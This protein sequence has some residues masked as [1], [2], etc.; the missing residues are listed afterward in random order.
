[1][2]KKYK[3]NCVCNDKSFKSQK[4]IFQESRFILKSGN[5]TIENSQLKF[6]NCS[7]AAE[8]SSNKIK[9]G[10]SKIIFENCEFSSP[11]F[12]YSSQCSFINCSFNKIPTTTITAEN[13][14]VCNM[15]SCLFHENGSDIELGAQIFSLDSN[16]NVTNSKIENSINSN[17]LEAKNSRVNLDKTEISNNAGCAITLDNS[18]FEIKQSIIESNGNPQYDFSQV[19]LNGS[20]GNIQDTSIKNGVNS[21]GLVLENESKVNITDSQIINHIK[22]GI[23]VEMYS[24]LR[25]KNCKI[26]NNGDEYEQT[27]Q[28]WIDN[29]RITIENSI[30]KDGVCGIYG[31]KNSY[32]DMRFC[33]I[34]GNVGGICIFESSELNIREC[35]ITKNSDKPPLWFE[36]SKISITNSKIL[37][38]D[39]EKIAYMENMM[40]VDMSN[41][42]TDDNKT[43][44]IKNSRNITVD[45]LFKR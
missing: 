40:S 16:I 44:L 45:F 19:L 22:N 21:N 18:L 4:S 35:L 7:F 2:E 20:T 37:E 26:I 38:N 10:N 13:G 43:T 5:L 29:S 17:G 41:N 11:F 34:I 27:L 30:V 14:S 31:Q 1:M 6:I 24:S 9:A 15:D 36:D 28:I 33:K 32:I 3:K 39:N 42:L 8:D 23:S 25:I 12:L